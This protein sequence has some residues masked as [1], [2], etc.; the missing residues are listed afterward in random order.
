MKSFKYDFKTRFFQCAYVLAVSLFFWAF[1]LYAQLKHVAGVGP[2]LIFLAI[3][4]ICPGAIIALLRWPTVEINDANICA[5]NFGLVRVCRPLTAVKYVQKMKYYQ[6]GFRKQKLLFRLFFVN[7]PI[8][9]I[10]FSGEIRDVDSLLNDLN[11][12]LSQESIPFYSCD[13]KYPAKLKGPLGEIVQ[14]LDV[15]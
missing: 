12:T 2:T 5:I 14:N 1:Y 3:L 7:E 15:S 11:K 13:L 8:L 9:P 10:E 6:K 4:P